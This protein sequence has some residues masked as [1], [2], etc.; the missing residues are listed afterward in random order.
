MGL[1]VGVAPRTLEDAIVGWYEEL[2]I[3]TLG[4]TEDLRMYFT[5]RI[6]LNRD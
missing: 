3:I 5:A 6:D 2:A 4:A 1:G